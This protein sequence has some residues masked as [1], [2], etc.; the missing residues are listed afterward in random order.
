MQYS[1]IIRKK[2][3]GYQYIITYKEND[4]D[5]KWKTK[6][7]QGYALNKAGKELAKIEM[8]LNISE[9]K[10]RVERSI[11]P[12]LKNITFKKFTNM[13]IE[14]AKLYRAVNTI[15]AYESVQVRFSDLNDIEINKITLMDIQSIIDKLTLEGLNPNT[16]SSY[17]T[18]LKTIF[19]SAMNEYDLIL[20]S[21]MIKL[22]YNVSKIGRNKRALNI[23]EEETIL[24]EI[25]N[26][27]YN[28][29]I[30]IALKC[31]LRIG[32]IIGL[33]WDNIDL[34]NAS[35]KVAQ[36]WKKSHTGEY[37]FGT[38]KSKN[39]YRNVPIPIKSVLPQLKNF[40]KVENISGRV[41]NMKSTV[42]TAC[43][44]NRALKKYNITVHE[45]RHTY[46]SKLIAKGMSFTN[47]AELLGNTAQETMRT[48]SHVN[49][50]MRKRNVKLINEIF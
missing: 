31:G 49:N 17:I 36:Q 35:I 37:D 34:K 8:D 21:P 33:T 46:G 45:L 40:K 19:N 3:K 23:A 9:L 18:R 12:E 1:T 11:D 42:S 47:A 27:D 20:K 48:Y 10:K 24:K 43:V 4:S 44:L 13:Y 28:M 6:S 26:K 30:L 16:I 50:D 2:D 39:S 38:L 22:K 41:F 5:I 15:T 14:H 29:I 32:E 25:K 7:K